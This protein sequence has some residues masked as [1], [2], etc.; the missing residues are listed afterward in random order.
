MRKTKSEEQL[1]KTNNHCINAAKNIVQ[2]AL[3]LGLEAAVI[4]RAKPSY[5]RHHPC[6]S[7][8]APQK[9][10]IIDGTRMSLG[11]AKQYVFARCGLRDYR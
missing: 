7:T 10:V 8:Y 1:E 3:L 9:V 2:R 4:E 6:G 5:R 11:Q